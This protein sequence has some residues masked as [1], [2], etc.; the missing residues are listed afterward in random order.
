M[1]PKKLER[2]HR[3]IQTYLMD[4]KVPDNRPWQIDLACVFLDFSAKRAKV[5]MFEN[6]IL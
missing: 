3:A 5:E 6:V 2:L 1:H 4:R